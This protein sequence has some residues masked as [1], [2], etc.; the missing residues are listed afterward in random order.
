MTENQNKAMDEAVAELSAMSREEFETEMAKHGPGKGNFD[1]IMEMLKGREPE[2]Q[3]M[4]LP[5]EYKRPIELSFKAIELTKLNLQPGDTLAITVKSDDMNG[6]SINALKK[7]M[8]Q[9]FPNNKILIFGLGLNDSLQF[10]ALS[11]GKL[12]ISEN[13]GCNSANYCVDCNCGKKESYE[14]QK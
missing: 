10:T 11:E 13:K 4:P 1:L 12:E 14:N 2:Y 7:G 3:T 8:E 6:D 9:N 5:P